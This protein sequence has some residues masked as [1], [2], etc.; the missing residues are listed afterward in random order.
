MLVHALGTRKC[1]CVLMLLWVCIQQLT[2]AIR[3]SGNG[4][5]GIHV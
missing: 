4:P 3:M 5:G 1:A 2:G